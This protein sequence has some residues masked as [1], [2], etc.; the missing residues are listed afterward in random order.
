MSTLGIYRFW[1]AIAIV[2]IAFTSP[3]CKEVVPGDEPPSRYQS[4]NVVYSAANPS[5]RVTVSDDFHYVGRFDFTL[6]EIVEGERF[7]FVDADSSK[8]ERLFII[9]F[10]N[11][12]PNNEHTYNYSFDNA[13]TIGQHK[14]RQNTWAY[15]NADAK[16]DNPNGEGSL[17][18]NYLESQGY[19]LEDE[20][21]M[22][23]F[24][25]VPD[26]A[27]RHEMILFYLE[28][29]SHTGYTIDTFYDADDN[30]TE[31]W[32]SISEGLTDRSRDAFTIQDSVR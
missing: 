23:R 17:T 28:N 14:Y 19:E 24:V 16:A 32:V 13:E 25:M 10:E 9:Q 4:D 11:F 12:L 30:P 3:G 27:R 8:V 18:A 15:S 21:M 1:P 31:H 26:S 7:V 6:K 22:S 2:L 20:L 5:L 29:A